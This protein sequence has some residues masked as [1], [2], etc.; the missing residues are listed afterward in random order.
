[1]SMRALP[2][3]FLFAAALTLTPISGL[4]AG[5]VVGVAPPAT[6][7]ETPPPPPPPPANVWA[8]GYWAWDGTKYVWVPGGYVVAP[9]PG[10]VWVAG[11]WIRG[12]HGWGW[13]DGHWR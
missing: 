6:V 4:A 13:H 2:I 12:G 3:L 10:A 7:V 8:P 9:Y 1:M 11:H 5:L